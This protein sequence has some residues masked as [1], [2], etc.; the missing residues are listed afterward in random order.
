M[1]E[2]PDV[3][4]QTAE[5][6]FQT[7]LRLHQDGQLARAEHLYRETLRLRPRHAD[8]LNM[9]GVIACQTRNFSAG[10]D[11]LGRALALSP[12]HPDY[13]NNLGQA[14]LELGRAIPARA[15]FEAA[16]AARPRFAEA[17]FNLANLLLTGGENALAEQHLR[18]AL[19][20]R[21]DYPDALNNLGNLLRQTGRAPE[22]TPLFRRL[23]QMLP[24]FAPGHYNLA[25]ALQAQSLFDAAVGAFERA[26]GLDSTA[27]PVWEALGACHRERGALTDAEKAYTAA[28]ARAPERASTW[29]ALGLTQ[30]AQNRATEALL[31][32]T[33][34]DALECNQADTLTHLGMTHAALGQREQ[35]RRHFERALSA[36]TLCCDAYRHL[37]E[38]ETDSAAAAALAARIVTVIDSSALGAEQRAGLQFT[39]GKLYDA[40]GRHDAAFQTYASA[41]AFRHARVHYDADGQARYIDAL[42]AT[43]DSAYFARNASL[44]ELSDAPVFIIG[45]PRSGTTLVEQIL[46]SHPAV[47]GAGELTFFPEQVARLPARMQNRQPF[48][49]CLSGN[50][51]ASLSALAADYLALLSRLAPRARRV[52]DKMP[53]NFLYLGLIACVFPNAHIVHCRRDPMAT[54]FSLYTHDLAGSHPY[55]YDLATLGSAYRGYQRLMQHWQAQLGDRLFHLDYEQLLDRPEAEIRGLLGYLGLPW[56]VRCLAFHETTRTVMTA[57]QWQVRRPL[58]DGAREHWQV[59]RQQLEPLAAALHRA[60]P[61]T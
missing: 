36:D 39:L 59:Y 38:L 49:L 42:I 8:A 25:L 60:P 26:L 37:S 13:H 2:S 15:S 21:A 48:P 24:G 45:M 29:T 53:Y 44:G 46:A 47:F 51:G 50:I 6:L 3:D 16:I 57:S 4:L 35:A 23:V 20:A 18:K 30:Y 41:N 58:Y 43:F 22:A 10:V 17:H 28:L 7:G 32:F 34:A 61:A 9:L 19:R 52:T 40:L 5:S 56:E 11:L 31:S 27:V 12:G 1:G 55:S 14:Q 54:C 33:R